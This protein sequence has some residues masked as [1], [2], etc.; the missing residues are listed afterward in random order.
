MVTAVLYAAL[1]PAGVFT[2]LYALAFPWWASWEGR[3]LLSSSLGM[4]IMLAVIESGVEVTPVWLWGLIPIAV[5]EWMK[6]VLV[7]RAYMRMK[8]SA[9]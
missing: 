2:A 8:G 9:E 3:G 5:A 4:T 7:Y 1:I 6:F